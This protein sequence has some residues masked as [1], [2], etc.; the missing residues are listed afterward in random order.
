MTMRHGFRGLA[1]SQTGGI[2]AL[3]S[4]GPAG[5]ETLGQLMKRPAISIGAAFVGVGFAGLVVAVGYLCSLPQA[6]P[7]IDRLIA[8][9]PFKPP[10]KPAAPDLAMAMPAQAPTATPLA[11]GLP[12]RPE[13]PLPQ[14]ALAEPS[15]ITAEATA[16]TA[17]P[18]S[19]PLAAA[20]PVSSTET[21]AR[22]ITPTPARPTAAAGTPS[23]P[24]AGGKGYRL[25]LGA[26]RT[27]ESAREEWGRLER[28]NADLLGKL[29]YA[30]PRVDLGN[31]GVFYRIQVGP[32]TEAAAADRTCNELKRRGV[33]C[34]LVKP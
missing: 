33:G 11:L 2:D 25:Q 17:S 7:K 27:P 14:S 10:A 32:V 21:V 28:Q 30:A 12:A 9:L 22:E 5:H 18:L 20:E 31:R 6:N 15:T 13:T 8:E 29:A 16:A 1:V 34:I 19:G 3:M 4:D 24:A 23:S 26:M